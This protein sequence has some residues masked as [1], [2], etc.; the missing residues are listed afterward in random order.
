MKGFFEA[1]GETDPPLLGTLE[2]PKT[3][4]RLNLSWKPNQTTSGSV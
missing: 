4:I 3:W 2:K 1:N